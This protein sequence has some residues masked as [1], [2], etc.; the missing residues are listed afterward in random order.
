MHSKDMEMETR[1]CLALAGMW[2]DP[3]QNNFDCPWDWKEDAMAKLKNGGKRQAGD[4]LGELLDKLD[5]E[6]T[7]YHLTI[8]KTAR[9]M[10]HC[11]FK[12]EE[13]AEMMY[14]ASEKVD[15]RDLQPNEIENAVN[16]VYDNESE[17]I[18]R[19]GVKKPE[20]KR[21]LINEFGTSGDIDDLRSRSQEIPDLPGSILMDLYEPGTLLHLSE[22]VF[23]GREVK[24]VGQW[25]DQGL[26]KVQYL[27]P[28]PLKKTDRGRCLDNILSRHYIVFESD[29]EGVAGN[30]DVQAG[31]I[32]RLARSMPLK[33]VVWSGNKSLHAWYDCR[34]YPDTSVYK[35]LN[36]AINLGA[37]K[38]SLRPSQLVRMPWGKRTDNN[39]TQKV[40]YYG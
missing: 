39:K 23:N 19:V 12:P 40:I 4:L 34:G 15:R 11:N 16:Y 20:V 24:T 27:T 36:L 14:N 35:F 17:E 1:L 21:H 7:G 29:M 13:T 22:E 33:M 38:S 28:N 6:G 37:D 32:D 30:W 18:P 25:I 5:K 2:D 3:V 26:D 8:M 9:I 10:K 31:L